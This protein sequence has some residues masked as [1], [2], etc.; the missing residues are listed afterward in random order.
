MKMSQRAVY[1][2]RHLRTELP[3]AARFDLPDLSPRRSPA[4]VLL[5][6][7]AV[8]LL[9]V[10]AAGS[11]TPLRADSAPPTDG[12]TTHEAALAAAVAG[13]AAA[14]A[15]ATRMLPRPFLSGGSPR[16]GPCG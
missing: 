16:Y 10:L 13:A 11:S 9:A 12:A 7:L 4:P 15:A 6:V 3:A 14:D 5:K 8:L 2:R 1:P